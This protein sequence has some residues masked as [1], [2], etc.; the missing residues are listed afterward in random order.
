MKTLT[1]TK[2]DLDETGSYVG[3]E[4]VSD[5]DGHIEIAADL[6]RV[7]F[8]TSVRALGRI[9]AHIGSGIEAGNGIEAGW[10]IEAGNGI[11]AGDGIKAGWGIEAGDGIKA[12]DGIEAGNGIEAGWGIEAGN[13][14]EAG[15]G[16]K[17]GDGI[18]AGWGIKAGF[19]ISAKILTARL[20]IFAGLCAWRLPTPEE[21]QIHVEVL[22][23]T[24]AFG[25]VVSPAK[26][27]GA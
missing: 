17:A 23:G 19:S 26:D 14:I 22:S 24:V 9:R 3:Q 13:G 21:M 12:G 18:K 15:W 8:S 10:G 4:D 6:G 27:G 16:I 5:F 7:K 11:E 1:I 25:E 2:A 20:R